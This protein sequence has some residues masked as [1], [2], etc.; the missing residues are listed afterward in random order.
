MN[1][2]LYQHIRKNFLEETIDL[3]DKSTQEKIEAF[4]ASIGLDQKILHAVKKYLKAYNIYLENQKQNKVSLRYY[5]IL[6]IYFTEVFFR[7]RDN[8]EFEDFAKSA[9]AYWMA[10]GSGKTI[11]MH[12]NVFQFIEHNKGFK[13][14]EI[15]ITTPGVN[16]ISQHEREVTPLVE[17][18]NKIHRNKI[19]FTIDTT[20]ALLNKADDFFDFPDNNKYQRLILVDEAHIGL[21]KSQKEDEG[22]FLK[23]RRRLNIKH[24]FLFEYSATYHNLDKKLENEYSKSIIYDYNY[25]LF[26]RDGYGKDFYFEKVNADVLQNGNLKD[27]L[28]LNFQ[29]IEE[30]LNVF[31]EIDYSNIKDLF[32]ATTFPDRPLIAFMG[33][34]VNDKKEEGKKDEDELSDI[35][36]I[37]DYLANLSE[38]ERIKFKYVFKNEYKGKLKL[39]RNTQADDEILLSYGTGDYWGI[40]NVGNG[41]NFIND[42][43]GDN[44]EKITSTS[45]IISNIEKYLF[46]NIDK[47]QSP[48]NVLI[49]SRKFAE[50]WNCFRVSVIGLINLG[51]SK[52][53]KIIQIFGRGVRLKGLKNDGK[54]KDMN[55]IEDYFVLE[56][57]ETDNLKKLE[58]LCVFSLQRS[59]LE[60]FTEAVS[61]ELEITKTFDIP[62]TPSLI[63]LN[64]GDVAFDTYKKDLKIFKLSK[65][66]VDVKRVLLYPEDKKIEY[67]FVIGCEQKKASISNFVFSLDYRT[68]RNE[69]GKN[70]R[71]SLSQANSKHEAF[72][73]YQHFVKNFTEQ[74]DEANIQLYK[75]DKSLSGI[76][77]Y[78]VLAY[79]DEIKYKDELPELDFE[80]IENVN[81]KI[82]EEFV[83]KVRNKINWHLNSSIYQYD[84]DLK[85]SEGNIKGDFIEKYTIVKSFK[86]SRKDGT[87]TKQKT[88]SELNKE[89]TNFTESIREIEEALIIDKIGN[90]IYEPLLRENKLVLK[91]DVKLT[92]D[93]L[94][95]GEKK[96]VKDFAAYIKEKPEK[97][98]E[99]DVYLMRNVESLKSIGIYL[100]D[101]SEVFY[102]DF[103][104]WL[105][106]K[107]KIYINF[108]DPKG[109]MGTKD[110]ST[111]QYK[112]KV[113]IADKVSNRTLTNIEKELK[114]IH[115]RDFILNSFILLRDSSDLGKHAKSEWKKQ[116]M[117]SRNIFRL[118]WH[119]MDER[120][121]RADLNQ[122]IDNKTYLDWMIEKTIGT[123]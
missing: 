41:L 97:F 99:F 63:K 121:N 94:N 104:M 49:G 76:T 42:Y 51:K 85:Q 10:T 61:S 7:H 12:I 33:N 18:L 19:R 48:I 79:I 117:I 62:V 17:Y 2:D 15:I 11:I 92:P 88:E 23:L 70:I 67:E 50:G 111:D 6:A 98:K 110:F 81:S 66:M 112:E 105:I 84:E 34:T 25:N 54:R 73:S 13:D 58:T 107:N 100:N 9:L 77:I 115:K 3:F 37:V 39:T 118:D 123:K 89:I 122:L 60:T 1:L 59:Y 120:E 72:I 64:S 103:I 43:K 116:N 56:Q 87:K 40:I 4:D 46:E 75:A 38:S 102:P 101:D 45:V 90:H 52:G 114:R 30:K 21:G 91:D 55:H 14:L 36:K 44:V 82:G 95:D 22:E 53:N 65:T 113:T 69:D 71:Y 93:K 86:L 35:S 8:K 20:S 78:D 28:D 109:Q 106:G 119:R 108:I 29:V 80:F 5:Q 74:A 96:F 47:P 27:N 31:N 57:S 16:L 26:Y 68:N 32:S 83:K 24:S